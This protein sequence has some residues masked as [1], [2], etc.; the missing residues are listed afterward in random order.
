MFVF[1]PFI[2]SCFI[3]S[4]EEQQVKDGEVVLDLIQ[5]LCQK[6]GAEGHILGP[7]GSNGFAV[8]KKTN[9]SAN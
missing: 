3:Q 6:P 9:K 1:V 7:L 4:A 2:L 8:E 5:D